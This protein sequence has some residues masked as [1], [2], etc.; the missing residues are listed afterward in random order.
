MCERKIKPNLVIYNAIL[1]SCSKSCNL[2]KAEAFIFRMMEEGLD[3]DVISFNSV[4]DACAKTKQPERALT[5]L[6]RMTKQGNLQPTVGTFCTLI[7]AFATQGDWGGREGPGHD[8][9][10]RPGAEHHQ[11]QC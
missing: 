6:S 3:P 9:G 11:F 2:A 7:T 8:A 1:D 5:W 10:A 4:I